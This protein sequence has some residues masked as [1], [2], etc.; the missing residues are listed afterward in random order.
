MNLISD[1]QF[2]LLYQYVEKLV[3]RS[4]CSHTLRRT[5]TWLQKQNVDV[6]SNVEK[7]I[8]L[9]ALCDC[10]LLMNVP[11]DE[12]KSNR[13][14]VVSAADIIG[15]TEAGELVSRIML[16]SVQYTF[17]WNDGGEHEA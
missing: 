14:T 3:N 8:D 1:E 13:E 12:W 11:P 9:G 4:G 7:C 6:R 10:E 15:P 2:T 5:R 16:Q 17:S